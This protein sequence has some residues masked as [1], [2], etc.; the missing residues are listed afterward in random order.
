MRRVT[1]LFLVCVFV[2]V[3]VAGAQTNLGISG[4]ALLPLGDFEEA[5][6]ISPYVG[7]RYEIQDVNALGQV[8]V[9]SYLI[10]GG[11]AFLQTDS[12]LETVLD[13]AGDK[14]DGYYF[15]GGVGARG[16]R[17]RSDPVG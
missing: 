11:F 2:G 5:T 9:L 13:A 1:L 15:E 6:D 10:Q 3:G 4:G 8:A 12:R 16:N 14:D 17:R 7:V